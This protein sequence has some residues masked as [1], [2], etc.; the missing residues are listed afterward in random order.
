LLPEVDGLLFNFEA[1]EAALLRAAALAEEAEVP[2]F[3]DA[4]PA[5]RYARRLWQRA[6]ILSPNQVEAEALV[7]FAIDSDEAARAAASA[8]LSQG[9]RAVILKL[10]AR[11]ALLATDDT[12]QF[13]PAFPV[14]PA[15][16]AGAGDAFTAGLVWARL[17][18]WAW[19]ESLRWANA[20]GALA[21]ARLGA[22][23]SMP[24]RA[25]ILAFLSQD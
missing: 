4:G 2:I 5:R 8:L 22:M 11:G 19:E 21:A 13:F 24:A 17:Q 18:G 3:V 6:A 20:C 16:T 15:D 23:P 14:R 1:P 9:P 10:G 12:M 7:G 25:E